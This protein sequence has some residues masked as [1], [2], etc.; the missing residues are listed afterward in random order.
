M[1]PLLKFLRASGK[2]GDRRRGVWVKAVRLGLGGRWF[3]D[4]KGTIPVASSVRI[5]RGQMTIA[6]CQRTFVDCLVTIG[7]VPDLKG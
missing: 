6:R 4:Y 2:N 3:G 5:L 1:V 7:L